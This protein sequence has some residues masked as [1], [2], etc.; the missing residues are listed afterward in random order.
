M[1]NSII[2]HQRD[3][4]KISAIIYNFTYFYAY[5][6]DL[7]IFYVKL[8]VMSTKSNSLYEMCW[9]RIS[10]FH[11]EKP[12]VKK[13][14]TYAPVQRDFSMSHLEWLRPPHFLDKIW[15]WNPIYIWCHLFWCL[16][17][18]LCPSC[19]TMPAGFFDRCIEVQNTNF[20]EFRL[21]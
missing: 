20:R 4:R 19:S 14:T 15:I 16:V 10:A 17:L 2:N 11:L 8:N 1:N 9:W 12:K 7:I 3:S 6:T 5:F 18:V 21:C 13:S